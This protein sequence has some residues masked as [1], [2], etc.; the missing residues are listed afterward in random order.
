V[1]WSESQN[2]SKRKGTLSQGERRFERN[3]NKQQQQFVTAIFISG[4]SRVQTRN[5]NKQQQQFVTAISGLFC[6][7]KYL[8]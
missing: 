5:S 6:V 3:S 1:N 7:L 2:V 8:F 4:L